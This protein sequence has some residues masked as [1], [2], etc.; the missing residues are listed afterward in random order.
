MQV[1]NHLYPTFERLVPLAQDADATP[2]MMLNLLKFHARAQYDDGRG[3]DISGREAYLRYAVE[4]QKIIEAAG[5]RFVFSGVPSQLII[6][7]VDELWD[8]VGIVEYPSRAAFHRIATSPEVM[9]IGV[10]RTAG[11]AGQLLIACNG[12]MFPTLLT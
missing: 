12:A 9:A 10:H 1:V 6:G 3:E 5:G 7:E 2:V 11:L 4:M 8:E